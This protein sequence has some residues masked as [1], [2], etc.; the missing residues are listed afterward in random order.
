MSIGKSRSGREQPKPVIGDNVKICAN[1]IV[2]G[3]ITIG[4]NVTIG[5]G[6]VVTKSVPSDCVVAGNPA[7][8]IRRGGVRCDEPL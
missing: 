8:I 1:A 2:I 4:D 6:S 5:A 3:G 7:R